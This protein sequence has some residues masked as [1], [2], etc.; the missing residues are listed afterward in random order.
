ML[1]ELLRALVVLTIAI[2]FAYI[3][4]DVLFDIAKRMID[5]VRQEAVPTLAKVRTRDGYRKH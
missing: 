3:V 1:F 5:F 4:F 2:P